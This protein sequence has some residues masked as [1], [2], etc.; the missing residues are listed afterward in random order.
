MSNTRHEGMFFFEGGSEDDEL[1]GNGT[2]GDY[3]EDETSDLE[4]NARQLRRNRF[5][6]SSLPGC[7]DAV[8]HSQELTPI[9]TLRPVNTNTNTYTSPHNPKKNVAKAANK[10]RRDASASTMHASSSAAV[11]PNVEANAGASAGANARS[12]P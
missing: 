10:E 8:S 3:S 4:E 1:L 12:N 5:S 6:T 7:E 9:A 11:A 2:E